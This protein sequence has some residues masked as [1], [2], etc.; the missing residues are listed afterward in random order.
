MRS[1]RC[2]I[3]A[4][5]AA[6]LA[7]AAAG[8]LRAQPAAPAVTL[9]SLNAYDIL[10]VLS[11]GGS[12][13]IALM[14]DEGVVL[15]DPLPVGL[16]KASLD[17]IQTVS[18]QPVRTI[19]NIRSD[20]QHLKANLEYPDVTKVVAPKTVADRAS[21]LGIFAGNAAKFAPSTIVT[22]PMTLLDGPDLMQISLP[23]PG[24]T[25][26]DMLVVFPQKRLAYLGDLF[27]RK[28]VPVVE[29]SSGGSLLG[30]A[31]TLITVRGTVKE[32][33]SVV[34]GRESPRV[35]GSGAHKPMS[36]MPTSVTSQWKDVEEY[37]D[38]V[39]AFV[40]LARASQ[41]AGRTPEQAAAELALP[42]RFK[43]YDMTGAGAAMT[44]FFVEI[45]TR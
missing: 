45:K 16:G 26:G 8:S 22:G 6:S 30:L 7:V 40:Q 28:A 37:A 27:P 33:R 19:V 11:G 39:A 35:G 25:N 44:A 18:D 21:S 42:E 2:L 5:V 31:Q 9:W 1:P 3:A 4:F 20:A 23:G 32:I 17:A 36:F 12:N 43:A 14:R 24:R 38:F 13:A 41:A 29:G 15:I 34:P 10:Y